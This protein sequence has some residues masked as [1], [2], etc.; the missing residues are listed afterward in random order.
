MLDA[1][2]AWQAG[3]LD[4]LRAIRDE[5]RAIRGLL[6]RRRPDEP[7]DAVVRLL[8]AIYEAVAERLFTAREL[9]DH[10]TDQSESLRDAIVIAVGALN[11][12]R[13]GH[14]LKRI[15]GNTYGDHFIFRRGVGRDGIDWRV[16]RDKTR[17]PTPERT[18]DASA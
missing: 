11:A 8:A 10:A 7:N 12:K 16:F 13:L 18:T 5:Q 2:A 3:V 14:L 4:E 1:Q 9:V 15:E 6:E 17:K